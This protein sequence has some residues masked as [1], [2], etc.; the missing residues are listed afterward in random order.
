M[1]WPSAME[2]AGMT[3]SRFVRTV[4]WVLI[5]IFLIVGVWAFFSPRSFYRAFATYP[6]FNKH[7]LRDIGAFN[8]GLGVALLAALRFRDGLLVALT[9]SAAAGVAHGL[10]HI[11]DSDAGGRSSDPIVYSVLAVIVVAA[12]IQRSKEIKARHWMRGSGFG[13]G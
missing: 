7:L 1:L 9:G 11:I 3:R 12:A 5:L 8:F 6:P 13:K 2:G 4:W 10:S